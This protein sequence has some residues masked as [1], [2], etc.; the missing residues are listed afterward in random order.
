MSELIK[1]LDYEGS[2]ITFRAKNGTTFINANEMAK[3]FGKSPSKWMETISAKEYISQLETIRNRGSLVFAIEGRNGGTWMHEDVAMEFARWLNP[4]FSIWCNDKI[5]ELLT[6][7]KTE[8]APPSPLEIARRLLFLEEEKIR[9]DEKIA[10]DAPKVLFADSVSE[11]KDSVLVKELS[12]YLSQNGIKK[13]GQNKLF[14]WL[15]KNG[16]LCVKGDYYNLPTQKAL[17]LK[18]F[19]VKKTAINKPD[20]T[21]L[22]STTTKVTG[23]GLIYFVNK[24]NSMVS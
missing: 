5:K 3:P 16:Y 6:T 20:G 12:G 17:D 19:E 24:F 2:V 10:L 13:M 21:I 7:G 8:L 18:L 14:E 22:T 4:R 11:T 15:R 9:A 1:S 23:K